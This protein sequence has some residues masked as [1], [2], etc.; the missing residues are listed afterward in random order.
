MEEKKNTEKTI[1]NL[2]FLEAMNK[3]PEDR[4]AK[5]TSVFSHE[6]LNVK[7]TKA[8]PVMT[9][10]LDKVFLHVQM[11]GEFA[12]LDVT[13]AK[14]SDIDFKVLWNLVEKY[15]NAMDDFYNE[16][17]PQNE[18]PTFSVVVFPNKFDDEYFMQLTTPV[19][20]TLQPLEPGEEI[21]TIT[22]YFKPENVQICQA[23][24]DIAEYKRDKIQELEDRE[25]MYEQKAL[26]LP[27]GSYVKSKIEERV[28]G[29]GDGDLGYLIEKNNHGY[30]QKEA[31]KIE[32]KRYY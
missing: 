23:E 13:F 5:C 6:T 4:Y 15:G 26:N 22:F 16:K 24:F 27:N 19:M 32:G 30:K 21:N 1:T 2:E 10:T 31:E 3:A 28:A 18:I 8:V 25:E 14:A 11:H 9:K 29:Y 12:R 7:T 17:M 20:W